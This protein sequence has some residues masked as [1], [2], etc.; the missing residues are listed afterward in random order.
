MEN[1]LSEMKSK[2]ELNERRNEELKAS[3]EKK[4]AE[5]ISILKNKNAQLN[6]NFLLF[7]FIFIGNLNVL[8]F[9]LYRLNLKELL[10][11][12]NNFCV[13]HFNHKFCISE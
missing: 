10:R 1:I 4:H 12:R 11:Q 6:V 13:S 9:F 8:S 3:E 2:S 5:E 7:F